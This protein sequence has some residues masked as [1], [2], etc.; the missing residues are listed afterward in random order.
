MP[1]LSLLRVVLR[2]GCGQSIHPSSRPQSGLH[3]GNLNESTTKRMMGAN[4]YARKHAPLD[5]A[6]S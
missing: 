6:A 2:L 5:S 3:L 1:L 4:A